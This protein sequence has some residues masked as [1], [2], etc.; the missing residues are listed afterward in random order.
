MILDTVL[1]MTLNAH[2]QKFP[3][4]RDLLFSKYGKRIRSG[5]L[6]NSI[7]NLIKDCLGQLQK[8]RLSLSDITCQNAH[9]RGCQIGDWVQRLKLLPWAFLCSTE[10][11]KFS[12]LLFITDVLLVRHSSGQVQWCPGL[13]PPLALRRK[14][15]PL[16]NPE[17]GCQ[18][19]LGPKAEK[20]TVRTRSSLE[21]NR[22]QDLGGLLGESPPANTD[23]RGDLRVSHSLSQLPTFPYR[24]WRKLNSRNPLPLSQGKLFNHQCQG[25]LGYHTDLCYLASPWRAAQSSS[26]HLLKTSQVRFSVSRTISPQNTKCSLEGVREYLG[27]WISLWATQHIKSL[28]LCK[29]RVCSSGK[30]KLLQDQDSNT[31]FEQ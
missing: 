21:R 17:R 11:L 18:R 28:M 30:Q 22:E 8:V 23:P 25:C 31:I 29:K 1:C 15:I 9:C 5:C 4:H 2:N 13:G 19:H 24:K 7:Q 6:S 10:V 14:K 16:N 3:I 26:Q 27:T 12:I 20:K